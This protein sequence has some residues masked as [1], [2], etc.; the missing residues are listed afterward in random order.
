[1]GWESRSPDSFPK[2]EA[3]SLPDWLP[4]GWYMT[5][6]FNPLLCFPSAQLPMTAFDRQWATQKTIWMSSQVMVSSIPP[7][8][9]APVLCGGDSAVPH[10]ARKPSTFWASG[11]TSRS[12]SIRTP[13]APSM[14]L[15]PVKQSRRVPSS[16]LPFHLCFGTVCT[17]PLGAF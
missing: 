12:A 10:C 1:M 5:E 8:N 6:L 16:F 13:I 9:G 2:T 14:C 3:A 15:A 17:R 4:A 11:T 7:M